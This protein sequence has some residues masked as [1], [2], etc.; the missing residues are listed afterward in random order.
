M[1]KTSKTDWKRLSEMDDSAIDTSDIAELD[2]TFFQ[3]AELRT[4]SK[5]PVTLRL[6]ADVLTWF[7]E[8]G[9][10]YQTRI[11]QLLRRYMESHRSHR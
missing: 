3:Q 7:K 8:G 6:D 2:E 5:Q 9:Q 10:G 4:P 11:N 1:K